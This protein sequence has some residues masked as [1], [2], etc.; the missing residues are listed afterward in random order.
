MLKC[1]EEFMKNKIKS[2]DVACPFPSWG[3]AP[4]LADTHYCAL[5]N[6]LLMYLPERTTLEHS[7]MKGCE[8][9]PR[10]KEVTE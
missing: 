3:I 2:E 4:F 9:C 8:K 7:I 6:K 5:E 10:C 1:Q